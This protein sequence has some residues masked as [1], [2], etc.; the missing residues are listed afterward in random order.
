MKK[1][2]MIVFCAV[3]F[4]ALSSCTTYTF[5]AP[6]GEWQSDNPSIT[7]NIADKERDHYGTYI[8][9]GEELKIYMVFSHVS[10]RLAIYDAIVQDENFNGSWE[11]WTYFGGLWVE[12]GDKIHYKLLPTWQDMYGIK[13][14]VFTKIADYDDNGQLVD[15]SPVQPED[16]GG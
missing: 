5:V 4:L 6:I 13:E 15:A 9:D 16:N 1:T 8:R 2:F 14:I 3:I 10:N 7:L 11:D 12:K